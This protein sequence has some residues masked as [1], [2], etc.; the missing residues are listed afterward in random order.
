MAVMNMEETRQQLL[1]EISLLS[2]EE[3]NQN[4]DVNTWSIAQVCHHIALAETSFAKA[5]RYGFKQADNP[6]AEPKAIHLLSDRTKKVKAPDIVV[7]S[8]N[9]LDLQQITNLLTESRTF[10]LHVLEQID[11]PSALSN[12][13]VPHPLFGDLPLNQWAELANLHE[14]RHIKQIK[15]I[16]ASLL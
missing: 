14:D 2:F 12:K 4:P 1:N 3:L 9:K 6:N 11:D 5:I 16:K 10:L 13:T 7:P 8:D 15:E